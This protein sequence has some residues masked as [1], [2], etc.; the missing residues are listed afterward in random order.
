MVHFADLTFHHNRD[1]IRGPYN[2]I[3]ELDVQDA[4]VLDFRALNKLSK[5]DIL[6]QFIC[7]SRSVV[8][9][10]ACP[11]CQKYLLLLVALFINAPASTYLALGHKALKMALLVVV[12][13]PKLLLLPV[14]HEMSDKAVDRDLCVVCTWSW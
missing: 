13:P 9:L 7:L 14:L 12:R 5:L 2:F 6:R 3:H 11:G 4:S 10:N 1:T 8:L